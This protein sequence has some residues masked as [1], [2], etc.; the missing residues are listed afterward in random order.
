MQRWPVADLVRRLH[1]TSGLTW[2]QIAKLCSVSSR[3]VR[4]WATGGYVNTR[5][6]DLLLD[7]TQAFEGFEE[8]SDIY[9]QMLKDRQSPALWESSFHHVIDDLSHPVDQGDST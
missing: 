5:Q 6:L 3:T 4:R 8:P 9:N 2:E 7:L 1:R